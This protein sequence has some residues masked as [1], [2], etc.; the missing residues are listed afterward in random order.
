MLKEFKDSYQ[1]NKSKTF[2]AIAHGTFLNYL[3]CMFTN[4]LGNSQQEFLIA[5][6][7]SLTILDFYETTREAGMGKGLMTFVDVKL[8]A[9]NLKVMHK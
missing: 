4:N 3:V 1:E 8:S 2:L 9:F 5:E 7:N 6:N